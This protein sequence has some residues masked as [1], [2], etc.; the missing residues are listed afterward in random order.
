MISDSK[1]VWGL[2]V[3]QQSRDRA[4]QGGIAIMAIEFILPSTG[5]HFPR[6]ARKGLR[7]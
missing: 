6:M 4:F 1:V 3:I 5:I 2:A 7:I